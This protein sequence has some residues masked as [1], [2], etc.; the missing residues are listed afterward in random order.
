MG[1]IIG[2]HTVLVYSKLRDFC[3][4]KC[5]YSA[6]VIRFTT[7]FKIIIF[8]ISLLIFTDGFHKFFLFLSGKV[9]GETRRKETTGET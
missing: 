2:S 6:A 8:C 4:D 1:Y 3:S 5:S 9:G 7:C